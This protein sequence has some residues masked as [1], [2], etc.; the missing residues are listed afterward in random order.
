VSEAEDRSD[1]PRVA[2][3]APAP[4]LVCTFEH[5]HDQADP[6]VAL[7][8]GGQG[9]WVARAVTVLG[10]TA[11]LVAPLGGDT[12][13]AASHLL[14]DEQYELR[15]VDVRA[16][17]ACY[18]EERREGDR[19][20]IRDARPGR[21]GQ[22]ELD[23]LYTAALTAAL[24][25]DVCVI[26]GSPW[27]DHVDSALFARLCADLSRL[28]RTTV[29]DL[30]GDQRDAA[31]AGGVDWLKIAH[32]ELDLDD[33]DDA[34]E[35]AIWAEAERLATAGDRTRNVVV[36]R[37]S[38]PALVLADGERHRVTVPS[39]TP[40]DTRG[41][42]DAMTAALAVG[43]A[44]GLPLDELLRRASAA[45]ASNAVHKGSATPDADL[46]DRLAALATV[47]PGGD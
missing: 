1:R 34:D 28:G 21:F 46:V 18:V 22:R 17:I 4:A 2:G 39:L 27:D 47:E 25:A 41:S 8:V 26:T 14:T 23:D 29:A 7:N 44:R 40:V 6:D 43:L 30:A 37:S 35:D 12:G 5:P 24:D 3:F 13:R 15:I 16:A 38:E 10:S 36:S 42:G 9:P 11:I 32:D 45:G 33:P 31:L 20:C 19:G